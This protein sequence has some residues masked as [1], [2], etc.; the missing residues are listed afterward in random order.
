MSLPVAK[1]AETILVPS[2][3]VLRSEPARHSTGQLAGC[4]VLVVDDE[5][6]IRE[7]VRDGLGVRGV[8][9]DEVSTGQEALARVENGA[10]DVVLCDLNLS[11][12]AP[13]TISGRELYTPI[14]GAAGSA[15]QK[16]FFL[17]MIG[18]LVDG[19][20]MAELLS[21]GTRTL[22][23]PFRIS[24]LI[25]VLTD[26]LAGAIASDPASRHA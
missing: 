2:S 17:F 5:P 14:V 19:T 12:G 24:E 1:G 3:T 13:G 15:V 20:A 26:A 9:V 22:Q 23:K 6:S 4:R 21:G 11:N 10:Y 18:E 7:L 8:R 16:P 25:A